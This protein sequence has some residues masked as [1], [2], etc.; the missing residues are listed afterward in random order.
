M[1]LLLS[2][3]L[4]IMPLWA[5]F[6]SV[7]FSLLVR[8][9]VCLRVCL[10][11]CISVMRNDLPIQS[12]GLFSYFPAI[13]GWGGCG[14]E[15]G[16]WGYTRRVTVNNPPPRNPQ[17]RLLRYGLLFSHK[18]TPSVICPVSSPHVITFQLQMYGG[19]R[20]ASPAAAAAST[21]HSRGHNGRPRPTGG[22]PAVP[23]PPPLSLRSARLGDGRPRPVL[24]CVPATLSCHRRPRR[25][26]NPGRGTHI[27]SGKRRIIVKI[28]SI[29]KD[30]VAFPITSSSSSSSSS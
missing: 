17:R 11:T 5:L 10:T 1:I 19:H 4:D 14:V 6:L 18:G 13:T 25:T 30:S 2:V 21:A 22:Q 7:S 16:G 24:R 26:W 15:M 23:G 3:E 12:L 20:P 29:F 27:E 28:I 8:P 9:S